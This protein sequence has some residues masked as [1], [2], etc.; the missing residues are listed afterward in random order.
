M[1]GWRIPFKNNLIL[2]IFLFAVA[3]RIFRVII[4][5]IFILFVLTLCDNFLIIVIGF[6][7]LFPVLPLYAD[8]LGATPTQIGL[9]M[10]VF[11]AAQL[12]FLPVW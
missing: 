10:M 2:W 1:F 5:G 9:I 4:T 12:L 6:S 7:V 11:A 3:F 8:R